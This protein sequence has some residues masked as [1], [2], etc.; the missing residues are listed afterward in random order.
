MEQTALIGARP[1]GGAAT[2]TR[3]LREFQVELLDASSMHLRA[4]VDAQLGRV[5]ALLDASRLT[6]WQIDPEGDA[7]T[8]EFEWYRPGLLA[9][10]NSRHELSGF[11]VPPDT[12][13]AGPTVVLD[14]SAAAFFDANEVLVVP[15]A[16]RARLL[17]FLTVG[18]AEPRHAASVG[19][20]P[21][22]IDA[23]FSMTAVI[24]GAAETAALSERA[25]YDELTGLANRRLLLFMLNHLLSRLGRRRG[26]GVAVIFCEVDDQAVPEELVVRLA[27]AF[28]EE[29]RATDMVGRFD[30]RVL[31]VLCD[32]LRDPAEAIEVAR[33][34]ARVCRDASAEAGLAEA[35]LAER[36][37]CFGIGYS[38]E[39]VTTGVLLR[40][41]DLAT[42]QA[43]AEGRGG[44]RV[45]AT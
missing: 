3:L 34:L 12:L 30:D 20:E 26:G 5:G 24:H 31:A 10:R 43:R 27:R 18:W 11:P 14:E 13:A 16:V 29:T 28:H 7:A 25:S 32:D 44:I 22:V 38:D 4:V 23:L 37:A 17:R 2:L 6:L 8:A 15:L 33:R 41:A 45:V 42:Y 40:R 19:I 39:A 1:A 36:V 21:A 35:G 9:M